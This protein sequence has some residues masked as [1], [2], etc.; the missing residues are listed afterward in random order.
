MKCSTMFALIFTVLPT[1]PSSAG[2]IANAGFEQPQD[3]KTNGPVGPYL[4]FGNSFDFVGAENGVTPIEGTKMVHYQEP[5]ATSNLRQVI[6]LNGFAGG[7]VTLS[8]DVYHTA[9]SAPNSLFSLRLAGINTGAPFGNFEFDTDDLLVT[10]HIVPVNVW[11]NISISAVVPPGTSFLGVEVSYLSGE[12]LTGYADNVRLTG[13]PEP[14]S[15]VL[16]ALGL[17]GLIVWR[18]RR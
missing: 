2:Q 13:V 10:S 3:P 8:A 7:L 12:L 17:I 15:F 9:A 5:S 6:E 11:T 16:A 14:S 18:R 1:V 4:W